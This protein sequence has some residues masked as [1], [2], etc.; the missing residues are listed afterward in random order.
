[1]TTGFNA[2][3]REHSHFSYSPITSRPALRLP[4]GAKLVLSIVL[5]FECMDFAVTAETVKDPRWRERIQPDPRHYSWYEYGNRV[6]I[7]RILDL[8]DRLNLRVTVAANALACER[9]P[10]LVGEFLGAGTRLLL[11]DMRRTAWFLVQ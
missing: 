5:H 1:M 4:G 10:F 3:D 11:T 9:Y 8:L 2:S 6:A 7:F